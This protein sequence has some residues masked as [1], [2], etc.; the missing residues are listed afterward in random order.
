MFLVDR[1][2]VTEL[3]KTFNKLAN[4]HGKI[5]KDSIKAALK[6]AYGDNYDPS[7]ASQMFNLFD[8]DGSK[9]VLFPS[10]KI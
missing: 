2:E 5:T 8:K 10:R 7:L 9:Y 4:K 3:M 6:K 1:N